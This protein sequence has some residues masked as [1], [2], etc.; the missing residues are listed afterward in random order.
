MLRYE[1]TMCKTDHK[2]VS[3]CEGVENIEY[4]VNKYKLLRYE[5]EKPFVIEDSHHSSLSKE[6]HTG[7]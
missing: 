1:V 3:E 4:G 2:P 6:R 5:G 7:R